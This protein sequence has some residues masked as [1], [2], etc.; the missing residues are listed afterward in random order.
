MKASIPS[1]SRWSRAGFTLIEMIGV[2]AIMAILS[3]VLVP[4]GLRSLDRASVVAEQQTLSN[5]GGQVKKYLHDYGSPPAA[6]SWDTDIAA[7]ANLSAIDIKTN[8]RQMDRVFLLDPAGFP[9]APRQRAIILSSMRQGMALPTAANIN[10]AARFDA[11][12]T[13]PDGSVPT[14]LSWGGWTAMAA[15]YLVIERINFKG[16][17]FTILLANKSNIPPAVAVTVCYQVLASNGIAVPQ[18]NLYSV[19]NLNPLAPGQS[20]SLK[21]VPN[22]RLNLYVGPTVASAID[23][24]YLVNS[25]PK[26]F[27][28]NGTHW[29]IP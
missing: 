6:A 2:L 13:T 4:N 24:S 18:A 20:V 11:L 14:A 19:P 26:Q 15:D 17:Y 28:F 3:A 10:N 1:F 9:A 16:E 25:S 27:D 29:I 21:L 7:Y 23:Y 12:W 5:L 8:K 22:E